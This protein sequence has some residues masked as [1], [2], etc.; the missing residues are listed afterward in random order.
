MPVAETPE[1]PPV[2]APVVLLAHAPNRPAEAAFAAAVRQAAMRQA[3]LVIVNATVGE[4]DDDSSLAPPSSLQAM[5]ARA[6]EA[7]VHAEV[8]QPVG[9]DVATM[10]LNRAYGLPAQVVVL[11]TR[12]RSAVGKLILGS[13]AQRVLME[14]GCEVL[15]VKA[16]HG[17]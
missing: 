5:V 14:A 11:G 10:I 16:S 6:A 9:P 17:G 4:S 2:E 3:R 7:G 15:L 1:E 13:T 8:E 12:R